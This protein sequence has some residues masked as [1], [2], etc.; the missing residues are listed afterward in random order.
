MVDRVGDTVSTLS[1]E[2]SS[3]CT[4]LDARAPVVVDMYVYRSRLTDNKPLYRDHLMSLMIAYCPI[5][6]HQGHEVVPV[7]NRH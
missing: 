4:L 6:M 3:S 2:H 5:G 1:T 7:E